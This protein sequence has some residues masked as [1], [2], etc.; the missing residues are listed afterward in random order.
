MNMAEQ[1]IF[2]NATLKLLRNF[3]KSVAFDVTTLAHAAI[4]WT[5]ASRTAYNGMMGLNNAAAIVGRGAL[6][7]HFYLEI[8]SS[9][10]VPNSADTDLVRGLSRSRV[11]AVLKAL[12]AASQEAWNMGRYFDALN[13][14]LKKGNVSI[15]I[16]HLDGTEVG[17]V[18]RG[19]VAGLA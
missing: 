4:G 1:F 19:K 14:E 11:P 3:K 2:P 9:T 5:G 17:Q 8:A 15:S 6:P 12:D 16:Y 18:E 7:P 10:Y 13:L